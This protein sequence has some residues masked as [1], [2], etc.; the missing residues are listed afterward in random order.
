M[1]WERFF[2][3]SGEAHGLFFYLLGP[4]A[5]S[6][7]LSTAAWVGRWAGWLALALGLR[8]AVIP[9]LPSCVHRLVAAVIFFS[10][11]LHHHGWR[12]ANR[13]V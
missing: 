10:G 2:L 8:H 1:V 12:M 9:L 4:L 13:R 11:P 5:A 3:N 6:V 7:S